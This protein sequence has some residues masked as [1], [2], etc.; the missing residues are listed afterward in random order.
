MTVGSIS[1]AGGGKWQFWQ[2]HGGGIPV[3]YR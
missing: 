1:T 2:R 3:I